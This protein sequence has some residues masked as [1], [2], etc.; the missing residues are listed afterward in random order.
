MRWNTWKTWVISQQQVCND[1]EAPE[2]RGDWSD[3]SVLWPW[4][5]HIW[6]QIFKYLFRKEYVQSDNEHQASNMKASWGG[7]SAS[8]LVDTCI[9]SVKIKDHPCS[10]Q[11]L[12]HLFTYLWTFFGEWLVLSRYIDVNYSCSQCVQNLLG[13]CRTNW[14]VSCGLACCSFLYYPGLDVK[15]A[16]L[17]VSAFRHRSSA[18]PPYHR[19]TSGGSITGAA[20]SFVSEGFHVSNAFDN[21]HFQQL[22]CTSA[23]SRFGLHDLWTSSYLHCPGMQLLNIFPIT[24]FGNNTLNIKWLHM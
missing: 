16:Y 23:E 4:W 10:T 7:W 18:S 2:S 24:S 9:E 5:L 17:M 6:N 8:K 3:A 13:S 22:V 20:S 14:E 15:A 11:N 21:W 1:E 19:Q 12:L